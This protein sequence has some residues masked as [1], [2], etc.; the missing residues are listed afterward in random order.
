MYQLTRQLPL[1]T[2]FSVCENHQYAR[3]TKAV[4][5]ILDVYGYKRRKKKT[6]ESRL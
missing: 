3:G 2:F 1:L 6:Y 5:T 4:E